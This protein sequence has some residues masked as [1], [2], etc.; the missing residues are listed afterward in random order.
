M[1]NPDAIP[2]HDLRL[3]LRLALHL[4]PTLALPAESAADLRHP[5]PS[6]PTLDAGAWIVW[7]PGGTVKLSTADGSLVEGG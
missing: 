3:A 2:T 1:P 7:L 5:L 4:P 6:A